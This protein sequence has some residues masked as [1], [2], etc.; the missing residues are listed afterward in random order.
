[1]YES[2]PEVIKNI[3]RLQAEHYSVLL[4]GKRIQCFAECPIKCSNP[5]SCRHWKISV[6]DDSKVLEASNF[7]RDLREV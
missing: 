2:Y 5:D 1:M 6:E 3:S 4:R 7:L